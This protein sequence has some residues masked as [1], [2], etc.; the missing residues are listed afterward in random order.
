MKKILLST[1]ALAAAMTAGAAN[2]SVSRAA[3]V[4]QTATQEADGTI[5]FSGDLS[6]YQDGSLMGTTENSAVLLTKESDGSYT[7][8]LKD[9]TIIGIKVGDATILNVE[10]KEE[11]GVIKLET[12]NAEASV[13]GG[14]LEGVVSSV[15]ITMT[16][17]VKGN[18]MTADITKIDIPK[19][20]ISVSANFESKVY[21]SE[22]TIGSFDED[23]E[24]CIPWTSQNN[25]TAVGTT[26]KGWCVSNVY[27]GKVGN[28]TVAKKVDHEDNGSAVEL[29][30][31]E[32]FGQKIPAYMTLG[33]TWA[34]AE[35]AAANHADGGAFGGIDF[36]YRPDAIRFDY[37]RD[38]SKGTENATAVA[39]LWKGTWTQKDVPGN[40]VLGGSATKTTMTDR[41][42]NILDKA[43]DEGGDVTHTSDAT[44]IASLEYSISESTDG[45]WQTLTV[46]FDYKTDDTPEKLNV[47]LSAN[48]YFAKR[49]TIVGKNSLTVDNVRL[50]YYHSLTDLKV[51][52]TTIANFDEANTSYTISGKASEVKDKL[53]YTVKGAGATAEVAADDDTNTVTITVKGADYDADPS[54]KTVYTI[55]VDGVST[56]INGV[57]AKPAAANDG[58]VYDLSG[59]RIQTVQKG[60]NI[61]RGNDGKFVKVMK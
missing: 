24:K 23:W 14:D 58:A 43:T 17:T 30:N 40:T 33:T 25:T 57:A 45:E 12:N 42:R 29:T 48:D 4:Q 46:P 11:N 59:R 6:V 9:F 50:V 38:N 54:S 55:S 5:S 18:C 31:G 56:G 26:P 32:T 19:M 13:K 8:V 3:E 60:L 10:G 1:M 28:Q 47:I 53:A 35:T 15:N 27:V 44:L 51:D 16:A 39:Y 20:G 21:P 37:I 52:G 49:T 41:D 2:W 61:V 22:Q 34:T 36:R 7:F